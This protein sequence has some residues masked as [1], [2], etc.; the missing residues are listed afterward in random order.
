MFGRHSQEETVM[1]KSKFTDQQ[2][3]FALKEAETGAPVDEVLGSIPAIS[4][5]RRD[6]DT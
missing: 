5:S 1:M 2:I 3:A 6:A 4:V